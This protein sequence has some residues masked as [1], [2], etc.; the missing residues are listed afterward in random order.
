VEK[1][2]KDNHSLD[3]MRRRVMMPEAIKER[4]DKLAEIR[5]TPLEELSS[6]LLEDELNK[7][8]TGA[9]NK[10]DLF[11]NLVP[12][13]IW[14]TPEAN[15]KLNSL[16]KKY[17]YSAND[18]AVLLVNMA[19]SS[20]PEIQISVPTLPCT[21]TGTIQVQPPYTNKPKPKRKR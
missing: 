10:I 15:E 8:Q 1:I 9:V 5:K 2:E 6:K 16:A 21:P 19:S 12:S 14:L 4:L 18:T 17:Q 7:Q 3:L 20:Q 11:E 13:S